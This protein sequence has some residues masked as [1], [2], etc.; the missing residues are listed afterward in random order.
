[1][2]ASGKIINNATVRDAMA[3]STADSAARRYI[4]GPQDMEQFKQSSARRE[5]LEFASTMGRSCVPTPSNTYEY[6]PKKPLV[7]LPPSMASLHGSLT[8]MAKLWLNEIPPSSDKKKQRFGNPAF[9]DW[10]AR[11]VSRSEAIVASILRHIKVSSLED[12]GADDEEVASVLQDAWQ[13]G[14]DAAANDS[15]A[16]D[17]SMQGTQ[18]DSAD[19]LLSRHTDKKLKM[20]SEF[21]IMD[22]AGHLNPSIVNELRHYL[23]DSFGHPV[24]LDYGTGHESSFLVFL[25]AITKLSILSQLNEESNSKKNSG[26]PAPSHSEVVVSGKL[27][28]S[29]GPIALS[30]FTQYLQVARS[31]QTHYIL[32]PAGSHGVWGLDDFYCLAFY[33]GACQLIQNPHNISPLSIQDK[34]IMNDKEMTDTYMYLS[35]IQYIRQI[36]TGVPFFESSPMLNDISALVSWEKVA[37]GLL[38]LYEGEVL[39]KRPV[40]QH[41]VF[42]S[43]FEATWSPS[44]PPPAAPNTTFPS[45]SSTHRGL[46]GT[47][48]LPSNAPPNVRPLPPP[49]AGGDF[50]PT[51]APWAK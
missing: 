50:V 16:E 8:A 26:D 7:G 46:G 37:K 44:K 23:H 40:V 31:V 25:Y 42:G 34:D 13:K 9:R 19:A 4:Y 43:L 27:P 18:C 21:Q 15:T 20:Y 5:L 6:N 17:A 47:G 22:G 11:L 24:R 41:F 39:D 30:L 45:P 12:G 35:C 29:L 3:S 33:F 48:V 14:Y 38:R 1:M 10:H 32:E 36:K 49:P 51:R 28:H 2:S